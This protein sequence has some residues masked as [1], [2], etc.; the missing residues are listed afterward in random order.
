MKLKPKLG[1][2]CEGSTIMHM[3]L[4][5][6]SFPEKNSDEGALFCCVCTFSFFIVILGFATTALS[7]IIE[8]GFPIT[9]VDDAGRCNKIPS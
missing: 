1:I 6:G 5:A 8:S 2:R 3:I 4:T 9:R 7:S